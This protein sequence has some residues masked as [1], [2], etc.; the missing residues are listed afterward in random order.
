M[1]FNFVY[2]WSRDKMAAISQT[3]FQVHFPN[4]NFLIFNEILLKFAPY[5]LIDNMAAFV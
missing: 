3:T 2:H 5:G 1:G 4:D